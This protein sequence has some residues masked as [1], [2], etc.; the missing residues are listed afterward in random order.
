MLRDKLERQTKEAAENDKTEK[1][2]PSQN[3]NSGEFQ[4][5]SNTVNAQPWLKLK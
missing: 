2:Y 5:D 3:Q 1:F 4:K